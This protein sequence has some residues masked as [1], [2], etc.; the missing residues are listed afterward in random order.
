MF[1][2]TTDNI[3]ITV[4][5]HYLEDQSIPDES[6]YVWAYTVVL[7]NLG[8]ETV[9]LIARYWHITDATGAVQEVRGPGVVGEQPTLQPGQGFRYT[10]AAALKTASG[11]MHGH[12]EMISQPDA[13]AFVVEI[14]T[15]SLDSPVQA[16]R[17]N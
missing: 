12:Y 3:R 10:S 9:Q 11:I 6:H 15:F 8:K 2:S 5:P 17:P 14:P 13:R 1:T 7:E 4:Q 16:A